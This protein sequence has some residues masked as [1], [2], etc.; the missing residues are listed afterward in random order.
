MP[1]EGPATLT[2]RLPSQLSA[3]YEKVKTPEARGKHDAETR[4][5]NR[6][7]EREEAAQRA[8][9]AAAAPQAEQPKQKSE[10]SGTSS[11]GSYKF[12]D[13]ASLAWMKKYQEKQKVDA[14]R[15]RDLD[16]QKQKE[17]LAKRDKER[18]DQEAAPRAKDKPKAPHQSGA[19][20][21]TKP[22][23]S[24]K[25][26][27]DDN[28]PKSEPSSG[29]KAR[30]LP[31]DGNSEKATTARKATVNLDSE[32]LRAVLFRL[33]AET[34]NKDVVKSL[35]SSAVGKLARIHITP[36]GTA[37]LDFI[38]ADAASKLQHLAR[39]AKFIVS[40]KQVQ[41]VILRVSAL[42]IPNDPLASRV[43]VLTGWADLMPVLTP[44]YVKLILSQKG[45]DCHWVDVNPLSTTCTEI[46]FSSLREA[47]KASQILRSLFPDVQ[48]RYG[49]DPATGDEECW[50]D[51]KTWF[52]A[53][54][55]LPDTPFFRVVRGVFFA[56][57]FVSACLVLVHWSQER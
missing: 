56:A 26:S 39:K 28:K 4:A 19:Q 23:R 43:L 47:R 11:G 16:A 21:E 45:H 22:A 24:G 27:H 54:A 55:D 35:A 52:A 57:T 5:R 13:R 1:V 12:V 30:Q 32:S 2:S 14:Q 37:R 15:K 10:K 6:E 9:D 17:M 53:G 29:G 3:A 48:V 31:R 44:S 51:V 7:R 50:P 8:R 33:D 18:R 20:D 38:T 46:H 36:S 42:S 41:G 34:S 49:I 25:K 40:G